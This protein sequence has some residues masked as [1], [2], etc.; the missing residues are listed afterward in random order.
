MIWRGPPLLVVVET[1]ELLVLALCFA[2][3]FVPKLVF[4]PRLFTV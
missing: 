1:D 2:F 3:F 4:F